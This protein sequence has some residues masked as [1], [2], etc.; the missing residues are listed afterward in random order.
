MLFRSD[1]IQELEDYWS[2]MYDDIEEDRDVQRYFEIKNTRVITLCRNEY[3]DLKE[4]EYIIDFMVYVDYYGIEEYYTDAMKT[5]SGEGGAVAVYRDG[6]MKVVS[7]RLIATPY[8]DISG[9]RPTEQ[10]VKSVEDYADKYN[11]KKTL[12]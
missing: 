10:I 4:V 5:S 1:A 11:C 2:D 9:M 3:E 12:K 7:N 6:D 8:N